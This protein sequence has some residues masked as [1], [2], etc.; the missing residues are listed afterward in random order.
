MEN[1][2]IVGA[3]PM[4]ITYVEVLIAMGRKFTVIGRG[5]K[6]ANEFK[7]KTEIDALKG[8]LSVFLD[9]NSVDK[10]TVAIIATGTEVLMENLI[11]L[12]DA[13]VSKILVEKP[14]AI[15][16]EELLN[17]EEKLKTY[18]DRIFIA[19]NRRFYASVFEAEK[20]IEEDGGLQSMQFEFTE[21]AHII[22]PLI[23]APGVKENWFFANSTHVVDLAFFLAGPPNSWGA[24]SKT[25]NLSWHTKSNF[26]GAGLTSNN[27]L[28]SYASNWE[29]AGRWSVELLTKNRRI[30][31][32]PMEGLYIQPKGTVALNEHIFDKDVDLKYKPGLYKQVDAF[33]SGV[34]ANKLCSLKEHMFNAK[35]IYS[36]ILRGQ[37]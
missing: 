29:S 18:L 30:Y 7:D 3:G 1:I 4:A 10:N 32:K 26:A 21:W 35:N 14:G 2:I 9:K 23:K 33:L 31:L 8:G 12:V 15:S 6:S 25:G 37:L 11:K 28:F 22:D 19:Y 16:I 34:N 20:L 27:V 24:Y 13:G 5:E 17:Q 36:K